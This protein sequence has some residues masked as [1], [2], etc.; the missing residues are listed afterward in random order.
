V[1]E[2]T[3]FRCKNLAAEA[4]L[5][6]TAAEPSLVVTAAVAPVVLERRDSAL[7]MARYYVVSIEPSLFGVPPWSA[8]ASTSSG[9][10][11]TPSKPWNPGSP[12]KPAAGMRLNHERKVCAGE[13]RTQLHAR[14]PVSS[15]H[16]DFSL[17]LVSRSCL[18]DNA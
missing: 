10:A 9:N 14:W 16:P 17:A 12:A 13:G 18:R 5:V 1:E 4:S 7:N 3:E 2:R 15:F 8:T 6:T 11:P